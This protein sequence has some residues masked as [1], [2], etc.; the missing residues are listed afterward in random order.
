MLDAREEE[1]EDDE[2][3]AVA[4]SST[5]RDEGCKG[6]DTDVDIDI[7]IV[8]A[9]GIAVDVAA[10]TDGAAA[11]APFF[12]SNVARSNVVRFIVASRS[13]RAISTLNRSR[14]SYS[15]CSSAVIGTPTR[16]EDEDDD[17][18]DDDDDVDDE[19]DDGEEE[20]EGD[21]NDSEEGEAVDED[22][23]LSLERVSRLF[24]TLLPTAGVDEDEDEDDD[25]ATFL[26]PVDVWLC[27]KG[28]LVDEAVMNCCCCSKRFSCVWSCPLSA[29]ASSVAISSARRVARRRRRRS[30][31]SSAAPASS[32]ADTDAAVAC[33]AVADDDDWLLFSL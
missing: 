24:S 8:V 20:G 25:E 12:A 1:V 17:V 28:T 2:D 6:E 27:S 11:L 30:S 16:E 23:T 15:A 31:S 21:D 5:K 33:I 13:L 22:V 29:L 32:V 7:D 18:D 4:R 19:K 3:D 14:A 26:G 10:V 9:V